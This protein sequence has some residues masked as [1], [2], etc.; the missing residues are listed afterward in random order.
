M[1]LSFLSENTMHTEFGLQCKGL[2]QIIIQNIL[3]G[4]QFN[5]QA[6]IL[7]N[8]FAFLKKDCIIL[9]W[10]GYFST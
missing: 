3:M 2:P 8:H 7:C 1:L 5:S 10:V 9:N 4:P 6:C